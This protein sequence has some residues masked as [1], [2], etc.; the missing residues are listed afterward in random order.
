[1]LKEIK[2]IDVEKGIVRI[3]TQDERWYSKPEVNPSTGLSEFRHYPSSTWIC[4]Y[5]PKG[6]GFYKWLA[7][8]GW[9]EAQTKKEE[10]G[11]RGSRVHQATE[12]LEDNGHFPI[13]TVLEAGELGADELE[14]VMAFV[15]W[16]TENR[17]QLLAKELTVFGN[18][19]AGTLDRIYRIFGKIWIVDLKTSQDIW[20]SMKLQISS[21]SHAD[22]DY[23]AL[24][25]TD[26]EWAGRKLAVLQLGYR[27]NRARFKFTEIDDKFE[28]FELAMKIWAN[29]NPDAKIKQRDFPLTIT[30]PKEKDNGRPQESGQKEQ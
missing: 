4:D 28:L 11:D 25:I 20:E 26:E 15:R 29:E 21:Y 9:D 19:Y 1:M 7:Q 24:G 13:D 23:K 18:G 17:P 10:A 3:T 27:K 2:T 8:N 16:W 22:I 6:I 14:A 30:L 5:Y 12:Y